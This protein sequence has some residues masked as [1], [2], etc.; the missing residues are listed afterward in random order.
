M[1]PASHLVRQAAA[2]RLLSQQRLR[3]RL[4]GGDY[5]WLLEPFLN[6]ERRATDAQPFGVE[7]F[8]VLLVN[9]T[10]GDLPPDAVQ[11][12]APGWGTARWSFA[13]VRTRTHA[14]S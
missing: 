9:L 14:L 11:R 1:G 5:L 2:C 13:S 12:Y 3:K 4:R 10:G 8:L 7:N 6:G